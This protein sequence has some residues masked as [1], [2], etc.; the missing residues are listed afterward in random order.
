MV[1]IKEIQV[2]NFRSI[3]NQTINVENLNVFVGN[4]DA[5]KSNVL[6][7][8][9][10]FFNEETD[11]NHHFH[12]ET[13]YS[14]L[15]P[16]RKRK[17][18]EIIIKLT[19]EIPEGFTDKG[20]VEWTKIW[21]KEGKIF[22]DM[23]KEFSPKSRTRALIRKIK[24][25]YVPAIKSDNY[26]KTLLSELY[27]SISEK[28]DAKLLMQADAYSNA[29]QTFTERISDTVSKNIGIESRLVMP[30]NQSDIFKEL[31]FSTS[32]S[33]VQDINLAYRGDGI[34]ARHI[35]AILKFIAEQENKDHRRGF[36]SYTTIWGYEEP[37]NGVELLKCFEMANEMLILSAN[38][39]MFITTHS[40]AFYAL[41]I[42]DESPVLV[43]Y[44]YQENK[45][46]GSIVQHNPNIYNIHGK[47]GILPLITP[48]IAKKQQEIERMEHI[49]TN[50]C[51]ID[52]DT[53]MVEGKSDKKLLEYMITHT[54]SCQKLA[55]KL[56]ANS[57]RI[58]SKEDEGGTTSLSGWACAWKHANYRSKL[59]VLLDHDLA[60]K[61][62]KK[63]IKEQLTNA[64]RHIKSDFY[65]PSDSIKSVLR[66]I[67]NQGAFQYELEHLLSLDFWERIKNT[68]KSQAREHSELY[69]LFSN[70]IPIDKAFSDFLKEKIPDE[71][72]RT[73]IVLRNPADSEKSNIINYAILLYESE[74]ILNMF[75]GIKPTV[76]K[77]QEYFC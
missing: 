71:T 26:F 74:E 24:Y 44:V 62:A 34:K 17:A 73:T 56:N 13:D 40:P 72:L 70:T 68:R 18:K 76:E 12:F 22:D 33:Q 64:Q 35:P 7:A 31:I 11:L 29:L 25:K 5:G 4:N 38:I 42:P 36:I 39:Q 43:N 57:L 9:N 61:T 45:H 3:V 47:I 60:G 14:K 50:N 53:I 15:A 46:Q 54:S 10:L 63:E 28:A 51:L 58:F 48:F 32:D 59:Y 8:L 55:D 65:Q 1:K 20:I 69:Q 16:S 77:L 30:R 67:P 37:E 27:D 21:R 66:S 2:I 41:S 49:L 52:M 23:N 75:D 19:I 6:K